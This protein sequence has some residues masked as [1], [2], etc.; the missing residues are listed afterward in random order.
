MRSVFAKWFWCGIFE[1]LGAGVFFCGS[2]V[3]VG[4]VLEPGDPLL[5][6]FRLHFNVGGLGLRPRIIGVGDAGREY[7]LIGGIISVGE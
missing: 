3:N 4:L 6:W 7:W 5:G 1:R 2:W